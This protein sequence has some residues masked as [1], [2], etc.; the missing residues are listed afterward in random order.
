MLLLFNNHS[1]K[2]SPFVRVRA[3]IGG[4]SSSQSNS[5]VIVGMLRSKGRTESSGMRAEKSFTD[6]NTSERS[7]S[8]TVLPREMVRLCSAHTALGKRAGVRRVSPASS[9]NPGQVRPIARVLIR[10]VTTSYGAI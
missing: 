6:M 8:S 3:G 10:C 4:V 9:N 1:S 2:R 7:K 5:I